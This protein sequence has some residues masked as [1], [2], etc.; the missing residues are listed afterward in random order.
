MIRTA[1][2]SVHS[3]FC[4]SSYSHRFGLQTTTVESGKMAAHNGNIFSCSP[5][6]Y[7]RQNH[8]CFLRSATIARPGNIAVLLV[9]TLLFPLA[10]LVDAS[11]GT[12]SADNNI[13]SSEESGVFQNHGRRRLSEVSVRRRCIHVYI[14]AHAHVSSA[15]D[16]TQFPLL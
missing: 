9:V 8:R 14:R 7:Q 10:F 2:P 6:R 11:W 4:S 1:N 13:G 5:N 15:H 12:T 16:T 3:L